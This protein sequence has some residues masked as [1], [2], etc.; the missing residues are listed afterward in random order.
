MSPWRRPSTNTL[1]EGR[2]KC[3]NGPMERGDDGHQIFLRRGP[4]QTKGPLAVCWSPQT[5]SQNSVFKCTV[6]QRKL[7]ILQYRQKKRITVKYTEIK[8][9]REVVTSSQTWF[10]GTCWARQVP[11][12]SVERSGQATSLATP[13]TDSICRFCFQFLREEFSK[14]LSGKTCSQDKVAERGRGSSMVRCVI[15]HPKETVVS[16]LWP[17]LQP[18]VPESSLS[19]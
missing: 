11:D 7:I 8:I 18:L 3:V 19:T 16:L 2:S 5:T 10:R 17:H 4:L 12:I 6:W 1:I 9:E 14:L 15:F 13:P